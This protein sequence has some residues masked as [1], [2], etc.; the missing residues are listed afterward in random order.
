MC[1]RGALDGLPLVF[2]R[3]SA[4]LERIN[5]R[6]SR[7]AEPRALKSLA[8]DY[9]SRQPTRHAHM[10]IVIMMFCQC[11]IEPYIWKNM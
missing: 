9:P 7:R 11:V 5:D 10:S 6:W 1:V 4:P 2:R 3:K 8:F